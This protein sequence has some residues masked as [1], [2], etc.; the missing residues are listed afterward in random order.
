MRVLLVTMSDQINFL[1]SNVLKPDLDYSA[2]VVDSPEVTKK[3]FEDAG[4][5]FENIFPFYELEECLD[6][7]YYD[8]VL[9]VSNSGTVWNIHERFRDYGLPQN[10]FLHFCLA[11]NSANNDFLVKRS[12]KY[13]Q[14]HFEEFDMFA[15]GISY[16]AVALDAT[17]FE[18]RKLFNFG[19]SS[20]DLYYDYKIAKFVLSETEGKEKIK[21]ALIGLAPESFHYDLS[22]SYATA[23][24]LL[25]YFIA[26]DDLHNFWLPKEEYRKIFRE[27]FLSFEITH[28]FELDENNPGLERGVAVGINLYDKVNAKKSI[29]SGRAKN[30]PETREENIKI[31]D[32]YLTLCEKSNVRPI[33]FLPPM[34]KIAIECTDKKRLN[35]F[36]YLVNEA[37]KKHSGAKFLDGWKMPGF[38]DDDF[39]NPPH[40]NL[41]GSAKFSEIFDKAIRHWEEK[42]KLN[43]G[44]K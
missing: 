41:Q 9:C 10:K 38:T 35:E 23:G 34:H 3:F 17:K 25:Q 32:D 14:E 24:R 1:L 8:F 7:F 15:T 26:F 5:N 39:Y 6:N 31:L 29:Y 18:G 21:Y 36:Y 37:V 13:Y 11:L 19:R 16:T 33:M 22:K 4:V 30:Y 44:A 43:G 20:Q 40:L 27:H 28:E 12:L 42:E 2:M